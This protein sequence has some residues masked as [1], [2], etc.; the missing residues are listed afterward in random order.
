MAATPGCRH[1]TSGSDLRGGVPFEPFL[2]GL[3]GAVGAAGTRQAGDRSGIGSM[4]LE[5]EVVAGAVVG[6]VENVRSFV[7]VWVLRRSKSPWMRFDAV[8]GGLACRR[9]ATGVSGGAGA[10]RPAR[11]C[12]LA[13][14]LGLTRPL[15][16]ASLQLDGTVRPSVRRD[17]FESAWARAAPPPALLDPGHRHSGTVSVSLAL[18]FR[19]P[20]WVSFGA[21]ASRSSRITSLYPAL[22]VRTR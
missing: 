15:R 6:C 11:G 2:V 16:A 17:A 4:Q 20:S 9:R 22:P 10:S 1:L 5:E 13:T 7:M 12:V 21:R 8:F 3:C 14:W 18:P 19:S